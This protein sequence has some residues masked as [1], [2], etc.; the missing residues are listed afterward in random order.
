MENEQEN[1]ELLQL[2]QQHLAITAHQSALK[3]EK[4]ALKDKMLTIVKLNNISRLS[5]ADGNTLTYKKSI[6]R[7]LNKDLIVGYCDE[8]K[9]DIAIFYKESESDSLRIMTPKQKEIIEVKSK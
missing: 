3:K 4:E 7:R 2:M 8:N 1:N 5:D 6:T 9:L